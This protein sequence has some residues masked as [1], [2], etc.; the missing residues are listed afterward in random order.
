MH[1][2]NVGEKTAWLLFLAHE[3]V[4]AGRLRATK[5]MKMFNTSRIK[6]TCYIIASKVTFSIP[7]AISGFLFSS[8]LVT[9]LMKSYSICHLFVKDYLPAKP[10]QPSNGWYHPFEIIF[11][12][13]ILLSVRQKSLTVRTADIIRL[14]FLLCCSNGWHHPFK[15]FAVPFE[16]LRHP[17]KTFAEPF[18]G[19]RNPFK[20]FP[21]PFER[22]Q[23]PFESFPRPFERCLKPFKRLE[24][25]FPSVRQPFVLAVRTDIR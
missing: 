8:L 14:N 15:T 25:P 6:T 9:F 4:D 24:H 23:H 2:I 19:L 13:A 5:K 18:E 17:F 20:I 10:L 7:L 3:S 12:C 22:L 16:R 11:C 21:L 1:P